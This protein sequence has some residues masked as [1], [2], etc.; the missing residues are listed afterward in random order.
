MCSRWS[1]GRLIPSLP[2]LLVLLGGC[3]ARLSPNSTPEEFCDAA[4]AGVAPAADDDVAVLCSELQDVVTDRGCYTTVPVLSYISRTDINAA[5]GSCAVGWVC[6]DT[7]V[8]VY[9]CDDSGA[10]D[11]HA[12]QV[13]FVIPICAKSAY[14]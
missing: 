7:E 9:P 10:P 1:T 4:D 8:G 14:Y 12:G 13:R 5:C 3:V 6:D 2:T 11:G